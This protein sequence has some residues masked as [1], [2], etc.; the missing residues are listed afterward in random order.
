[1]TWIFTPAAGLLFSG[2]VVS[3]LVAV[4]AW[5]KGAAS[6]GRT[7]SVMMFAVFIWSAAQALEAGF[8]DLPA[9]IFFSQIQ[10]LGV[11]SS[12]VLVF[13]FGLR[14]ARQRPFGDRRALA[15]LWIVPA[16]IFLL[17]ATN[18]AHHL[19]WTSFSQSPVPG[20]NLY[21]YHHGPAF[22]VGLAYAYLMVALTLFCLV[23]AYVRFRG[24]QRRQAGALLAAMPWPWVAN[25]IYSLGLSPSPGLD[26]TP[27]GFTVTG[28]IVLWSIYGL[29]LVDLVPVARDKVIDSMS[30]ALVILDPDDRIMALNPAGLRL[31]QMIGAEEAGLPFDRLAGRPAARIFARWPELVRS[32]TDA[33]AGQIELAWTGDGPRRD[34]DLRLSP[35]A[36]RRGRITGW[37][38]IL[39]DITRLKQ[40]E[41]EAIRGRRI[42]ETLHEIGQE[43]GATLRGSELSSRVLEQLRKV[44]AYDVG[45]FFRLKD[46][47]LEVAGAVGGPDAE[48]LVGQ[49]FSIDEN[50]LCSQS[51]RE[52]AAKIVPDLKSEDIL[53]PRRHDRPLRSFLGVPIYVLQ[54]ITG[55]LALYSTE[56]H[57]FTEEDRHVVSVFGVQAGIALENS[58]LYDDARRQAVT[59][60]LTGM[61]NRRAF[62]EEAD[63]EFKKARRYGRPLTLI[64]IDLDCFKK[65]NDT[66]GHLTGDRVLKAVA[67]EI[68]RTLRIDSSDRVCR[69]GGEEFLVMLAETGA[70]P[71][72]AAA[73]RLRRRVE[74]LRI[75]TESGPAAVTISLGVAGFRGE[76]G[77]TLERLISLADDAM[78]AAKAAGRNRVARAPEPPRPGPAAAG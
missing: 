65:V 44:I 3:L 17:A 69:Y 10:Y 25:V 38:A 64:M 16:V 6:G 29:Q 70:G 13:L 33:E 53:L 43:L 32:L 61:A 49:H 54:D 76:A 42:A 68:G 67:G 41:A 51:L 22:W 15:G 26:Y 20:S 9:K 45:V 73:E 4:V 57:H 58:R 5:R 8:V 18:G 48:A 52:R 66:F 34:F 74:E 60:N 39:H 59:D 55:L 46:D 40:T 47:L 11:Q 14:F 31:L 1:M 30:D 75:D 71:A 36:G 72:A 12:P 62:F 28:A 56:P 19:V 78:Y 23:R 21:L 24:L 35:I 7:L 77:L 63:R 27:L 50:G 2:A 37:V